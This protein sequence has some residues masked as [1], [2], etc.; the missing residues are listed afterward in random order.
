MR[1]LNLLSRIAGY[2]ALWVAT[3]LGCGVVGALLP[4]LWTLGQPYSSEDYAVG[5][6][7]V[8]CGLLGLIVGT[9]PATLVV[10]LVSRRIACRSQQ[11]S[12]RS[13]ESQA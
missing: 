4:V 5:M 6:A 7:I 2:G 9:L 13:V 8:F 10:S 11:K 3:V 12:L 1:L